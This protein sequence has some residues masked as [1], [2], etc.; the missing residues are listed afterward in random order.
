[1]DSTDVIAGII[2]LIIAMGL[3]GLAVNPFVKAYNNEKWKK[4]L[5]D[6]EMAHYEINAKTG[7]SSFVLHVP[8]T[9]K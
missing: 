2:M 4:E 1:M 7:E 9:E 8:K 6:L 5:V 3:G